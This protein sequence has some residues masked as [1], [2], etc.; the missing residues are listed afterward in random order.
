MSHNRKRTRPSGCFLRYSALIL[1]LPANAQQADRGL[2]RMTIPGVKGVLEL[3]VGPTTPEVRTRPDG[4]ES[5]MRALGR[6]DHLLITAFLQHV[7]FPASAERCRAE[8]WPGTEKGSRSRNIKLEHIH[9]SMDN[10]IAR[11]EY[12][13]PEVAGQPIKQKSLHAY[14]GNGDLCAEIHMSKVL[15]VPEEQKLFEDVLAAVRLLPDDT[16]SQTAVPSRDAMYFLEQGSRS[17]VQRDYPT[18]AQQYQRAL[19]LEKDHRI[20]SQDLFRVL[21]D[22]LG[23]S[24]GISGNLP[25]AKETFEYGITQDAEYP[26]FYYN[27]ACTYGEMGKMDESLEQLR[28][29]YKYKTNIIAGERFPD[30]LKDDSFRKFVNDDKFVHAVREMQ[31]Q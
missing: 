16:V 11:V 5:Q 19:D 23:M 6:E 21:V 25:K 14:L 3:N 24:Y 18:A 1:I 10:E 13:V 26:I 12:T 22:N 30:P 15:F 29:A 2:V 9:Q 4:L 20:L 27:M 17:Y 31:K 8:W 7:K 28:L